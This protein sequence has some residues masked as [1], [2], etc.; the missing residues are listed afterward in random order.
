MAAIKLK[1]ATLMEALIAM[2]VVLVCCGIASM[3]FVNVMRSGNQRAKL[4]AH[5]LLNE[6]AVK[7]REEKK[8]LDEV[9]ESDNLVIK[10]SVVPYRD[11]ASITVL[12]LDAM[13]EN[14]KILETYKE[15]ICIPC[16]PD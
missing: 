15:L 8:F 6:T 3:I 13:D 5:L 11:N 14:D 7:A 10:K 16:L 1:A 4:H 2:V 12:T 9:I